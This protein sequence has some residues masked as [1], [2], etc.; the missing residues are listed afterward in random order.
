VLAD[1]KKGNALAA[2][3]RLVNAAM[4]RFPALIGR[5]PWVDGET[6][7]VEDRRLQFSR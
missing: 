6:L 1:W 7:Q 2:G 5:S 3:T 4:E